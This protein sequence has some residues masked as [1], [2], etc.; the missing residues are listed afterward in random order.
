MPHLPDGISV[1][2]TGEGALY[3]WRVLPPHPGLIAFFGILRWP[4][5]WAPVGSL[6]AKMETLEPGKANSSDVEALLG[7]PVRVHRNESGYDDWDYWFWKPGP[8]AAFQFQDGVMYGR[9]VNE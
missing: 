8:R 7:P 9:A 4:I 6:K 5:P 3:R 2:A 1:E